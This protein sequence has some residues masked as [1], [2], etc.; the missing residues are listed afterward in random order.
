MSLI[1][2]TDGFDGEIPKRVHGFEDPET[3]M[4]IVYGSTGWTD[5]LSEDALELLQRSGVIVFD[6]QTVG[7]G[8]CVN[9]Y[10]SVEGRV[11]DEKV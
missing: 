10:R 3:F 6:R 1:L 11:P 4:N 8:F 5:S 9:L 7:P 2:N